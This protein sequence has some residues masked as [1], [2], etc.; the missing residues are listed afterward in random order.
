MHTCSSPI[1]LA[2]LFLSSSGIAQ[3][4]SPAEY[5]AS[6]APS[7][8][9]FGL[10]PAGRFMFVDGESR[11]R[12]RVIKELAYRHDAS[13]Y[14]AV[15][16][17]GRSWSSVTLDYAPCDASKQTAIFGAVPS[18]TTTRVFAGS[19]TWPEMFGHPGS[20]PAL[21]GGASGQLAFPFSVAVTASDKEDLSFDY[22]FRGG[23]LRNSAAWNLSSY[24]LDGYDTDQAVYG[25][26]RMHGTYW[27]GRGCI[28]SGSV[29]P[30]GATMS[31][32]SVTY[33]PA[34]G[35]ANLRNRILVRFR[36]EG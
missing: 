22:R 6:E 14:T 34:Y 9:L 7:H 12:T 16:G 35:S 28:D 2:I 27:P 17:A 31:G 20:T 11:G 29:D 21:W 33:G 13:V 24:A 1:A 19:V 18:A 4:G 10:A 32:S 26:L 8:A 36:S 15:T 30:L 25:D 23:V 3:I 5:L